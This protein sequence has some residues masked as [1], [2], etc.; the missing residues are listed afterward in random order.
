MQFFF[1]DNGFFLDR[2]RILS[3]RPHNFSGLNIEIFQIDYGFFPDRAC[4]FP[5]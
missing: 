5:G 1:I 4:I 2:P 3:D